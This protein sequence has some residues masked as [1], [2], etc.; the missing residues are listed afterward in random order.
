M[1][2]QHPDQRVGVFVDIG[3]MYHSAKNIYNAK[4]NFGR[5]LTDLVNDRQLVRAMAYIIISQSSEEANFFDALTKQG[6]ELKSK[7]LQIFP[8]GQKKGDWDVGLA[9]DAITIAKHLDVVVL[10]TGDG[11]FIPLVNYL[12]HTEGCKVEIAAFEKSCSAK[13]VEVVDDFI[14]LSK[15][16]KKYLIKR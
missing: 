13:L 5:L 6:Y 4:I 15:N 10:V 9:V 2:K 8:G 1:S 16:Y 14:N 3:N 11:D 12:K 7:D